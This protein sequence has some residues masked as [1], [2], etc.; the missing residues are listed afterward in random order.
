MHISFSICMT[1]ALDSIGKSATTRSSQ[2]RSPSSLKIPAPC[3][4]YP[5]NDRQGLSP[6]NALKWFVLL[7]LT[8]P[9]RFPRFSNYVIV[10]M[11]KVSL[12]LPLIDSIMMIIRN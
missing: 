2:S 4:G 8:L 5:S 3:H 7:L 11:T 10:L 9:L 12:A 1:L 6:F